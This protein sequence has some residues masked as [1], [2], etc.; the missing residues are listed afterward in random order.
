MDW[1]SGG[2]SDDVE[3]RRS[4]SGGGGFNFGGGGLGIV[5]FVVL[6]LISLVT[7]RNYIGS[8]LSGGGAAP[9]TR[10]APAQ[11]GG[12]LSESAEEDRSA[13]LVSFVLDDVQKTWP[14]ILAE[15]NVRYRKA[16][17]VLFRGRTYSG[18]G[19]A[20]AATGPFYCPADEKVYIDL[21]FW[22]ELAKLGGGRS[23]F[24]QAY[25]VAHEL[26]HHV[27]KILGIES[28]VR[29]LSSQDPAQRNH[30]S[31][32]LELQA[33]CFA[34]VW[35]HSTEERKIVHESDIDAGLKAAAA[36][37]DDHI[38]RMSRG[39]VS[40][41]SFTHGTSAQRQMWFRRGLEGG[42]VANCNTFKAGGSASSDDAQ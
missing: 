28:Q 15:Q 20:Q 33:D 9:Q 1:N 8:Y 30:L 5:G 11:S 25:V 19:T 31:V 10:S 14:A 3:D 6:I 29:R 22:D 7:G 37:G 21:S 16:K 42:T 24:A 26:G 32:D 34:G 4:D 27:Q 41:E 36:V 13:H 17:L 39:T 12:R 38:Q 40:P 18:C 35:A 2:M 23:E